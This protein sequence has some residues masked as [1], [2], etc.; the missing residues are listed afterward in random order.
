MTCDRVETRATIRYLGERTWESGEGF[1]TWLALRYAY[2]ALTPEGREGLF[3][4]E[5]GVSEGESRRLQGV[6][7]I[8][9]AY[10]RAHPERV[11][12]G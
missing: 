5:E 11:Q 3:V 2:R 12:R 4:A 7:E 8:P 10:E 6:A 1:E 9:V